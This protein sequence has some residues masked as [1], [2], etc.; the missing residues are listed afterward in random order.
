QPDRTWHLRRRR[1]AW[2]LNPMLTDPTSGVRPG[3]YTWQCAPL[4]L[5]SGRGPGASP[6]CASRRPGR[7]FGA[8]VEIHRAVAAVGGRR[9]RRRVDPRVVQQPTV[10]TLRVRLRDV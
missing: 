8:E 2:L 6:V 3:P 1:S 7:H 9:G 4:N 10:G 5:S